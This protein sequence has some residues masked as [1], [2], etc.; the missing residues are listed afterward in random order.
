MCNLGIYRY[1]AIWR[2]FSKKKLHI[3]IYTTIKGRREISQREDKETFRHQKN[4]YIYNKMG[5]RNSQTSKKHFNKKR[6]EGKFVIKK[7]VFF[8]FQES[9]MIKG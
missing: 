6:G 1:I 8:S 9:R 5:E 3:Y 2:Q 4:I 7:S